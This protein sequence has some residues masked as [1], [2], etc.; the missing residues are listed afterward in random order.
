MSHRKQV[1]RHFRGPRSVGQ[2]ILAVAFL[3]L[4]W[5]PGAR[6]IAHPP[7]PY[8]HGDW[9]DNRPLPELT[10]RPS[11][12]LSFPKDFAEY[13]RFNFGYRRNLIA[14]RTRLVGGTLGQSPSP[15][16]IQGK[17]GWLFFGETDTIQDYRGLLP[18]SEPEL[19]QW[20]QAIESRH[21]WLAAQGIHYIF[22]VCPDKH[23][24]YPEYMPNKINRVRTQ[25][26][27]DQLLQYMKEH[28]NVE[29]LDLRPAVAEQKRQH[30]CYQ[31]Q[32]SHWNGV[33]SFAGYQQIVRRLRTWYPDLRGLD[34][35]DCEIYQEENSD[36][37]LLRLQAGEHF[38][39]ITDLVRPLRGFTAEFTIDPNR[40]DAR[41][42]RQA[43][44]YL[45]DAPIDKLLVIHDSFGRHIVH[46]LAE[47]CRAGLYLW[48][49]DNGFFPQD[50]LTF[51]PDVVVQE[52]VERQLCGRAPGPLEMVAPP[53]NKAP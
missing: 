7:K 35:E 3:L 11:S 48:I 20:R 24:I 29:I 2:S 47:H 39:T 27:L 18:F 15:R 37:D 32:E 17:E 31:P 25:T 21:N 8:S 10:W 53:S 49:T 52:I 23:T 36:T 43:H 12:I 28:S 26:R 40:R 4:I 13:F 1:I 51:R 9:E 34:W 38:T 22:V 6:M 16:V 50:V 33:G 5:L 30:L 45:D 14:M 42:R 19:R 44:S 41:T 46:F